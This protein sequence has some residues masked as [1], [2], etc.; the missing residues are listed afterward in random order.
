MRPNQVLQSLVADTRCGVRPNTGGAEPVR[1]SARFFPPIRWK[2][3]SSGPKRSPSRGQ[4]SNHGRVPARKRKVGKFPPLRNHLSL[5]IQLSRTTRTYLQHAL[6]A[7]TPDGVS[8]HD[9]SLITSGRCIRDA[10]AAPCSLRQM[11]VA[12]FCSPLL[13]CSKSVQR[14]RL[15]LT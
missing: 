10:D 4:L 14:H 6:D 12:A 2:L 9:H 5:R 7:R 8:V 3:L 13:H 1:G 11:A 15:G